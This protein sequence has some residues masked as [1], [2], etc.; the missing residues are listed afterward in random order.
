MVSVYVPTLEC[1]EE[2]P[3]NLLHRISYA[4]QQYLAVEKN[5]LFA[6]LSRDTCEVAAF[7]IRLV[8]T[9]MLVLVCFCF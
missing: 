5:V 4:V 7:I 6:I 2:F 3:V 8:I 1:T 9:I